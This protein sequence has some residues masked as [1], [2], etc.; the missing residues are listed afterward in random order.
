MSNRKIPVIIAVFLMTAVFP[1]VLGGCDQNDSTAKRMTLENTNPLGSASSDQN[2]NSAELPQ[3]NPFNSGSGNGNPLDQKPP[4]TN[5]QE[6]GGEDDIPK[7]VQGCTPGYQ[8][9]SQQQIEEFM[10]DFNK[11]D[12]ESDQKDFEDLITK[13]GEKILCYDPWECMTSNRSPCF[14]ECCKEMYI[15]DSDTMTC[16]PYTS[17]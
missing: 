5:P 16:K 9:L 15:C 17:L 11:L 6:T 3:E 12:S 8:S 7:D 13:W 10:N 2:P 14:E 1:A 4:D